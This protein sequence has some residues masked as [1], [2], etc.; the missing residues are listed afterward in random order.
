MIYNSLLKDVQKVARTSP[1]MLLLNLK[2]LQVERKLKIKLRIIKMKNT[3][4]MKLMTRN[5]TMI[6]FMMKNTMMIRLMMK[7]NIQEICLM[8]KITIMMY[9]FYKVII[10]FNSISDFAICISFARCNNIIRANC[11]KTSI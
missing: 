6:R 3:T 4:M 10:I 5:T 11:I 2:F 9:F 7:K 8:M 1:K